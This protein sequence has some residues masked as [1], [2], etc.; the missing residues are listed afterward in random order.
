MT[1]LSAPNTGDRQE[2]PSLAMV[3]VH[4][5]GVT[6]GWCSV[7][8]DRGLNGIETKGV[9]WNCQTG[10]RWSRVGGLIGGVEGII[11]G[12]VK[13]NSVRCRK[14]LVQDHIRGSFRSHCCYGILNLRV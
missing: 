7:G 14:P 11:G 9:K 6:Q 4:R 1:Q 12:S 8:L 10:L 13:V 3:N 2:S 5:Y